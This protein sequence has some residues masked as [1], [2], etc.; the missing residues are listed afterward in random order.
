MALDALGNAREEWASYDLTNASG[1]T[2]EVKSAAYLQTWP[3]KTL[4]R[5]SF[6]VAPSRAF[7]PT[8]GAYEK[9]S[10]RQ[11]DLYVFCF[12]RHQDPTTVDP[13]DIEQWRFWVVPTAAL[14][15]KLG[16]QKTIGLP[17]FVLSRGRGSTSMRSPAQ[18]DRCT[19]NGLR[20]GKRG[21]DVAVAQPPACPSRDETN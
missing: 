17:A 18:F 19:P 3:Q 15:E 16:T 6:S 5:I 7:D 21:H 13:L 8:T 2:I 4:S 14:D 10:R 11:A 9:H 20:N 1:K 12:L